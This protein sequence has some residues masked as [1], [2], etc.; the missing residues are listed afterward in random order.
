MDQ[1]SDEGEAGLGNV[2]R[3][4]MRPVGHSGKAK[5]GHLCFDASF[6]TVQL[7]TTTMN[8]KSPLPK[9]FWSTACSK[10][11]TQPDGFIC[12]SSANGLILNTYTTDSYHHTPVK[13]V[14]DGEPNQI[15]KRSFLTSRPINWNHYRKY[16]N[17]NTKLGIPLKTAKDLEQAS[18][19]FV[20]MIQSGK[21]ESLQ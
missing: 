6:E 2:T 3:V 18:V 21:E 4:I 1:Y 8:N 16:L 10:K 17:N 13:L 20:E 14:I 5:K 9:N 11:I 15:P 12:K 19:T 7:I